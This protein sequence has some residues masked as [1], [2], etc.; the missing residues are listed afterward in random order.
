VSEA[1]QTTL[2]CPENA[3]TRLV[4]R[5]PLERSSS[6]QGRARQ[7]GFCPSR[8]LRREDEIASAGDDPVNSS[9]PSGMSTEGYCASFSAFAAVAGA[10]VTDCIVKTPNGDS[11][12]VMAT[13]AISAGFDSQTLLKAESTIVK[14][15]LNMATSVSVKGVVADIKR[16]AN[17]TL[18]GMW[19]TSNAQDVNQLSGWFSISTLSG[20]ILWYCAS[21]DSF[22]GHA[23]PLDTG[24][25]C[26]PNPPNID[27]KGQDW[28]LGAGADDGPG[29][30]SY[31]NGASYTWVVPLGAAS[32]PGPHP[33]PAVAVSQSIDFLNH[34]NILSDLWGG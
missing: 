7:S 25:V 17:A 30:G 27:V 14:A 20:C 19:Q 4:S 12:G 26:V 11:T 5:R 32:G 2:A 13:V 28:G 34:F 16:G 22:S 15:A 9:D 24:G 3:L 6:H 21:Y 23:A 29:G 1:S 10:G 18:E 8:R 31:S 33:A